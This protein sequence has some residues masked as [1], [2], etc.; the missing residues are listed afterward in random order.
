MKKIQRSYSR[1]PNRWQGGQ[2]DPCP[3]NRAAADQGPADLIST[4]TELPILSGGIPR[5][6]RLGG[7]WSVPFCRWLSQCRVVE[8][9]KVVDPQWKGPQGLQHGSAQPPGS[10]SRSTTPGLSLKAW[11]MSRR[12]S[13]HWPAWPCTG[14]AEEKLPGRERGGLWL[15]FGGDS[16]PSRFALGRGHA[17]H[18]SGCRS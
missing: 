1:R 8:A 14:Y 15:G 6:V 17:G 16:W 9:W 2:R 12:S 11:L 4:G 5:T 13:S 7:I 10:V 18:R 3:R